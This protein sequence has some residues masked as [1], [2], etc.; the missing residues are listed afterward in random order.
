M[1]DCPVCSHPLHVSRL[2]CPACLISVA[3]EFHLPPLARLPGDKA[4]LAQALILAGGNLKTLARELNI[5]YP[6]LRKR[7]DELIVTLTTLE[8]ETRRQTDDILNA[9]EQDRISPD[10]GLRAIKELQGEL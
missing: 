9:I 1:R 7:L 2:S 5:T 8:E 6:T 10:A 3:G 4:R